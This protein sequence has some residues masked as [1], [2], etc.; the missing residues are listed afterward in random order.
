[1]LAEGGRVPRSG[2][3]EYI[4]YI[5]INT[6]IATKA[7]IGCFTTQ[8]IPLNCFFLGK[9]HSMTSVAKNALQQAID[10][11]SSGVSL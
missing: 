11:I 8:H 2:S 5:P 3:A 1:M 9:S 4:Y 7:T 10:M 6:I